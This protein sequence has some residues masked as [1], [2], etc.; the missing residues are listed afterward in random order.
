MEKEE[1]AR[2]GKEGKKA[3]ASLYIEACVRERL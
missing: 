3:Q 1:E 2:R